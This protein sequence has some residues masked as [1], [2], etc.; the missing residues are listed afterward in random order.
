MKDLKIL[1]EIPENSKIKYEIDEETWEMTVDRVMPTAFGFP[2]NYGLVYGTHGEDGDALDALVFTSQPVISGVVI[3]CQLIGMLEMED[4][5]GIDHKL[6]AV[7]LEKV[8]PVCGAWKSM[9]DVPEAK[10]NQI[11]HFFEHYK[12]L[13]KGKWVKLKD[14]KGVKE[15]QKILEKGIKKYQEEGGEHGCHDCNCK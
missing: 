5:G 11:R 14:W 6:V 12:D 13:E 7:P 1:I 9:S 4:E 2:T 15:A 10:K 3:K 8:D